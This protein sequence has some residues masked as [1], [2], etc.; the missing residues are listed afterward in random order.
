M[1]VKKVVLEVVGEQTIHCAGCESTIRR[2]LSQL[3]GVKRVVPSRQTQRVEV[4]L[5]TGRTTVEAL[6]EKL[7]WMGWETRPPEAEG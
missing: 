5:D 7:A 6:R 3:P 1:A 4:L 2:A